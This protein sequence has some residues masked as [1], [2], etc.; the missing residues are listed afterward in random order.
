MLARVSLASSWNN[1]V[2]KQPIDIWGDGAIERDYNYVEDIVKGIFALIRHEGEGRVFNI[3]S[4]R[5]YS[6]NDIITII[7]DE[8]RIPVQVN[9]IASRGFDVPVNILDSSCLMRETGW[10]PSVDLITGMRKVYEYLKSR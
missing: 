10:K 2:K 9:Y 6:L 1:V 7:R 8:L 3:S 4:G 5:G